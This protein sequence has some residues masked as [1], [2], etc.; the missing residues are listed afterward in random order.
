MLIRKLPNSTDLNVVEKLSKL[1]SLSGEKRTS[2]VNILKRV[3]HWKEIGN[4]R[5]PIILRKGGRYRVAFKKHKF[6]LQ[7][8]MWKFPRKTLGLRL[9]ECS[10]IEIRLWVALESFQTN[11]IFLLFFNEQIPNMQISFPMH[12]CR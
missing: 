9:V 4:P 12:I 1:L 2:F 11:L 5:K 7:N 6:K 10:S 3:N 8:I